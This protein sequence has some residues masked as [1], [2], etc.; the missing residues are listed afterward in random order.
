M[1]RD[2]IITKLPDC[3]FIIL[4]TLIYRW[5][6]QTY[7]HVFMVPWLIRTGSGLDDWIYWHFLVQS[8]LITIRYKNS[9]SIFSRTLLPWRSRTHSILVLILRLTSESESELLYDW[10]CTANQFVLATSPLRLTISNFIFQLNI[11]AYCP[12]VT[13]SLRRGWVHH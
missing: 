9:Q 12:Y 6:I 13:T 10:R 2:V 11:C 8:R 7:C 4:P 5:E 3:I 1:H